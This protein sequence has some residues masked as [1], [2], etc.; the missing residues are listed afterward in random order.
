MAKN[1]KFAVFDSPNACLWIA[2]CVMLPTFG[3]FLYQSHS[4]HCLVDDVIIWIAL[5][6]S[7]ICLP[8]VA[9]DVF[10]EY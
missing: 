7:R 4:C 5:V 2:S 3:Q 9:N 6:I 1:S 10:W 8:K